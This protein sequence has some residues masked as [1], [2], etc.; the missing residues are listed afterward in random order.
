VRRWVARMD[1]GEAIVWWWR[2]D[3]PRK[4]PPILTRD[5]ASAPYVP[6]VHRYKGRVEPV[7]EAMRICTVHGAYASF[8]EDIKGTLVPGKL[9]DFV[10]L[11]KDPHDVDPESIIDIKVLRTV[12]GGQTVHEA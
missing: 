2:F 1:A 12:L 9:A 3:G 10:I 11:E 4:A 8:E 6:L 7:T 5:Q